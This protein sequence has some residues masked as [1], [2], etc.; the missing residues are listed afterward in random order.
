MPQA[1]TP[2]NPAHPDAL[3]ID[4]VREGSKFYI[5]ELGQAVAEGSF[6]GTA[7]GGLFGYIDGNGHNRVGVLAEVGLTPYENGVW[8]NAYCLSM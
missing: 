6:L 1:S 4:D 3:T 2:K 7:E 5:Y 8:A